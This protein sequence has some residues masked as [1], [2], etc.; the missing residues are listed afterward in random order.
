MNNTN[1]TNADPVP[2]TSPNSYLDYILASFTLVT[3]LLGL[4]G[5]SVSL[6]YFWKLR[7]EDLASGLYLRISFIDICIGV[8]QIPLIITLFNGREP[9]LFGLHGLCTSWTVFYDLTIRMYLFAILL[10]SVSR[11]IAIVMPMSART[12]LKEKLLTAAF[13]LYFLFLAAQQAV[14]LGTKFTAI[15]HEGGAFCF[16]YFEFE[17]AETQDWKITSVQNKYMIAEYSLLILETGIP[18]IIVFFCFLLSTYKLMGVKSPSGDQKNQHQAAVTITIFCAVFLL[19]FLPQF[20]LI[21]MYST[22][23][24]VEGDEFTLGGGP[25]SGY[26]MKWYSWLLFRPVINSLNAALDPLIYYLRMQKFREKAN[27]VIQF[28]SCRSN[29]VLAANTKEKVSDRR[30][31]DI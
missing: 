31:E 22:L 13:Y 25:F 12:F 11:T 10:L 15:Y 9:V 14:M 19:C 29:S 28:W 27:I 8:G 5:N 16:P 17:A 20:V 26:F 2:E 7:K 1:T 3:S 30:G 4:L 18:P 6:S 21:F 23:S 24:I